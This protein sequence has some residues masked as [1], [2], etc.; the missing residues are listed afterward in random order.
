MAD[1]SFDVAVVGAGVLGAFHAYHAALQ[2]KKVL[3]LE[4][5]AYPQQA[6]VRNFGQIV[7]SGMGGQWFDF[8]RRS[9]E[10]YQSIQKEF[11]ISIRQNGSVY[12]ASDES[13]V[14]LIHELHDLMIRRGYASELLT[15]PTCLDKWPTLNSA[16]CKEGLFFPAELSAEPEL[17]IHR[18]IRFLQEKFELLHYYPKMTVVSCD[19]TNEKVELIT[20]GT[21]KFYADKVI[22][23]NGAEFKLLFPQLFSQ[24][25]I[26]VS[27]LQMMKTV[28]LK[29]VSLPGNIL[30]GL[31]IRRYESFHDCPSFES[32]KTPDHLKELKKWGVHILFKQATDGSVIIGDS[33]EYAPA[34][35][36]E[37]LNFEI[38]DYINQL[39]LTEAERIVSFDLKQLSS[40]WAG[41]YPQHNEKDIIEID[42]EDKVHIRTAI[43]GKGMTSSAGYAEASIQKIL[44]L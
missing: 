38:N 29:T 37:D 13:E 10:I 23:C 30:T 12:I 2:H 17:M 7:P 21:E 18:L 6:T 34:M 25:G 31:T 36:V 33:H 22:I 27:K 32:L 40:S 11:D 8:G 14:K 4:K 3:L 19:Y 35:Q 44:H 15:G 41:Y 1:N 26:V 24:S 9:L 28:P 39:I 43:G 5:D 20:T 42:I 16:Y